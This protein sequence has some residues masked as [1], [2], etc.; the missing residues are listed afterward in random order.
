[1]IRSI[2]SRIVL[3]LLACA[4]G[5]RAEEP[6]AYVS[7]TIES[8]ETFRSRVLKVH[9]FI[10]GDFHYLAYTVE[11]RGHEVVV[12]SSSADEPLK[13]GDT[14]RCTMRA[15]PARVG[16]GK[17]SALIFSVLSSRPASADA[18]R[19]QA[20]ADEVNRR[21]AARNA[22]EDTATKESK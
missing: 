14:V 5:L 12:T 2:K 9:H 20:V 15:L 6:K 10:E 19:L 4:L 8:S 22:P 7:E 16:E 1:M 13:E 18:A 21:R 17:K 11:W 3:L